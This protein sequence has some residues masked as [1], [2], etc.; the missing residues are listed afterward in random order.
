LLETK[1]LAAYKGAEKRRQYGS[2]NTL[3]DWPALRGSNSSD[4]LLQKKNKKN[5]RAEDQSEL[6]G[7][8]KESK[9][10]GVET[11]MIKANA[12]NSNSPF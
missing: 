10:H 2:S 9:H 12:C 3:G 1:N 6:S 7:F 8:S 11:K 4:F 5:N